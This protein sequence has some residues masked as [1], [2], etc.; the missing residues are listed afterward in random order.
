[1][2]YPVQVH[3]RQIRLEKIWIYQSGSPTKSYDPDSTGM[4]AAIAAAVSNDLIKLPVGQVVSDAVIP[5]NVSLGGHGIA[6]STLFGTVT[7]SPGSMILDCSVID[8]VN[9]DAEAIAVIG[10]SSGNS[11]ITNAFLEAYNCGAG[12]AIGF[13]GMSGNTEINGVVRGES[14]SGLGYGVYQT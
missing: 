11:I 9:S 1:M 12:S 10:C 14:R 13:Y 6:V 5:T 3:P 2:A 7:M 8:E 4:A